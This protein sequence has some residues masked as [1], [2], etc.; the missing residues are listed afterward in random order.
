MKWFAIL[1]PVVIVAGTAF[2]I[3]YFMRRH[4]GGFWPWQRW[5]MR[6]NGRRATGVV[7]NRVDRGGVRVQNKSYVN[8]YDLVVEVTLEGEQPYRVSVTLD[9]YTHEG[10]TV[11]GTELPLL[12]HP[13]DRQ[14]VLIDFDTIGE[15]REERQRQELEEAERKRRALLG[16]DLP[17]A[18]VRS[19]RSQ[20]G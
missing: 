11:E 9:A 18:T 3:L 5:W 6:R 20:D 19:D 13:R 16:S 12:V 2:L 7:L 10:H 1:A 14:R 4:A 15:R 17:K 8:R